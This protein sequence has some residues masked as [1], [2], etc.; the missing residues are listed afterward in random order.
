M[1]TLSMGKPMIAEFPPCTACDSANTG[2]YNKK[3]ESTIYYCEDCDHTWE[4]YD[5]RGQSKINRRDT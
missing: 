5:D 2:E 4:E 3:E 1:P